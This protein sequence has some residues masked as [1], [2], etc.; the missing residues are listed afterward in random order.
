MS[1]RWHPRTLSGKLVVYIVAATCALLVA[2]IS[3]SY[4]SARRALEEQVDAEALKQ[5]RATAVTMDSYVDRVGVLV[6]GI[7]ARQET[8]GANP[9]QQTIPLLAHLLDTITPEEAYG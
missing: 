2:T 5:V 8:I 9:D 7:A 3:A 1:W 6:R 4:D